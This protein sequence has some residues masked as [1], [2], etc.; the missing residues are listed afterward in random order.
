M[1]R[2]GF[3]DRQRK[4]VGVREDGI[5]F[6]LAHASVFQKN[7]K[8]NKATSLHKSH[9][10]HLSYLFTEAISGMVSVP[11]PKLSVVVSTPIRITPKIVTILMCEYTG[12]QRLFMR[13]FRFQSVLKGD[14]REKLR[15]SWLRPS[16]D[17][18]K[19]PV[20]H[21]KQ[22]LVPGV[23]SERKPRSG[24]WRVK[25]REIKWKV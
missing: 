7:E 3:I 16:A 10:N 17:K 9:R 12:C 5:F 22:P 6:F 11:A 19:L 14:P 21:E 1:N 2:G 20:A 15:R 8:K 13:G 24:K 4:G 18:T 23:M 25:R